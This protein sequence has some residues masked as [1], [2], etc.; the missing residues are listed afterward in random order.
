ME[1]HYL[2]PPDEL[3]ADAIDRHEMF[4]RRYLAE[5]PAGARE[6]IVLASIASDGDPAE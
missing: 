6:H 5:I 1:T 3:T 2:L 4:L